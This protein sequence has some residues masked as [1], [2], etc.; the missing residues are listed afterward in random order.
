MTTVL[1]LLS[2]TR[3]STQPITKVSQKRSFLYTQDD[4]A[5]KVCI[6]GGDTIGHCETEVRLHICLNSKWLQK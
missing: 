6:L 1:Q 4:S 2:H 5:G 3:S